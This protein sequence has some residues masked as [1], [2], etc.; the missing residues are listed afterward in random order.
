MGAGAGAGAGAGTVDD[1]AGTTAGTTSSAA[2]ADGMLGS[3]LAGGTHGAPADGV[4]DGGPPPEVLPELA[5]FDTGLEVS[6]DLQN[7]F[8]MGS[9]AAATKEPTVHTAADVYHPIALDTGVISTSVVGD[10]DA[11]P[12]AAA[13]THVAGSLVQVQHWG[14][15]AASSNSIAALGGRAQAVKPAASGAPGLLA[16]ALPQAIHDAI[17]A[18]GGGVSEVTSSRLSTASEGISSSTDGTTA[19]DARAAAYAARDWVSQVVIDSDAFVLRTLF[20]VPVA[21]MHILSRSAAARAAEAPSMARSGAAPQQSASI[22]SLSLQALFAGPAHGVRARD[23]MYGA[24]L[25]ALEARDA[26]TGGTPSDALNDVQH[27][28]PAIARLLN[29]LAQN[30]VRPLMVLMPG[31]RYRYGRS[32]LL[33]RLQKHG[34]VIHVVRPPPARGIG[35]TSAGRAM[36]TAGAAVGAAVGAA[37]GADMHLQSGS[38]AGARTATHEAAPPALRSSILALSSAPVRVQS[39]FRVKSERDLSCRSGKF[40][41]LEYVEQHPPLLTSFGM[42]ARFVTYKHPGGAES[43]LTDR[44]V[45]DEMRSEGDDEVDAGGDAVD[46]VKPQVVLVDEKGSQ[47]PMLGKPPTAEEPIRSIQTA[48]FNAP[49]FVHQSKPT[50]FLLVLTH[51]QGQPGVVDELRAGRAHGA[52]S[53]S[54]SVT[55][56]AAHAA[57]RSHGSGGAS[58]VSG[59]AT[60]YLREIPRVYVVGQVEPRERVFKP[61]VEQRDTLDCWGALGKEA[62]QFLQKLFRYTLL[63]LFRRVDTYSREA[64]RDSHAARAAGSEL[65]AREHAAGEAAGP[66]VRPV[67]A[68]VDESSGRVL[69]NQLRLS[70]VLQHMRQFV[71]EAT[72]ARLIACFDEVADVDKER[73]IIECKK[74]VPTPADYRMQKGLTLEQLCLFESFLFSRSLLQHAGVTN[75]LMDDK[76]IQDALAALLLMQA[77]KTKLDK[78]DVM[79]G[80]RSSVDA[81]VEQHVAELMNDGF[82]QTVEG[83]QKLLRYVQRSPW[84]VTEKFVHVCLHTGA[85][86]LCGAR[87]E[88]VVRLCGNTSAPALTRAP[89]CCAATYRTRWTT[90]R[91]QSHSAMMPVIRLAV[92]RGSPSSEACHA[93]A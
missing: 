13:A 4:M 28:E 38:V 80:V 52:G 56:R 6:D 22:E 75:I 67:G 45:G 1:A 78:S 54:K 23:V 91:M 84:A 89:L 57:A 16:P 68:I 8:G 64:H 87:V 83:A 17:V 77:K 39:G 63:L 58:A 12:D 90:T 30:D 42:G 66:L 65:A 88:L 21:A 3:A 81:E 34:G 47:F 10:V 73:N 29:G 62:T 7:I 51:E 59:R 61:S 82:M 70:E 76:K 2:N 92:A 55:A 9:A 85:G 24:N 37:A 19:A 15:A 50:D 35:H 33:Q 93:T 49:V 46:G 71:G 86:H 32:V 53:K 79:Q 25:R 20:G 26:S 18:L 40:V 60:A 36:N 11:L 72:D 69:Q 43:R 27:S 74:Q 48:L 41:V 31:L 5:Y 14:E 44:M